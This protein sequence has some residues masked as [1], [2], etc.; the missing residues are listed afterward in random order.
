VSFFTFPTF[1]ST[2]HA[3]IFSASKVAT[4]QWED[5]QDRH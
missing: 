3:V 5:D 4:D 2:F 1:R